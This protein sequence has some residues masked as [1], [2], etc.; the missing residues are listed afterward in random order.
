MKKALTL[1]L[2]TLTSVLCADVVYL[3]LGTTDENY[4]WTF[5]ARLWEQ[6]RPLSVQQPEDTKYYSGVIVHPVSGDIAVSFDGVQHLIHADADP[7]RLTDVMTSA[8]PEQITETTDNVNAAKGTKVDPVTL[9]PAAWSAALQT[10]AQ[11]DAAGWFD[12]P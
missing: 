11:M 12:T 6:T 9:M 3:P 7:A 4:G 8:T 10:Q 2:L 1:L 5:S